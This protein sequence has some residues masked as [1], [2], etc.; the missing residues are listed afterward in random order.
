[1][2][3]MPEIKSPAN[4]R[5]FASMVA[6]KLRCLLFHHGFLVL[7]LAFAFAFAGTLGLWAASRAL[8]QGR[9]DLLDRLGLGNALHGR[10]LA[11]EA[12]QSGFIELALRIGLLRLGVRPEEIAN[13]F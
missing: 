3:A 10:N 5:A 11:R 2:T 9:F 4:C 12:V 7:I 1:M 6:G 8:G 13:H